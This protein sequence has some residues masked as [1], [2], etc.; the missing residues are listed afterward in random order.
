MN[1][2]AAAARSTTIGRLR[3]RSDPAHAPALRTALELA[4]WPQPEGDAIV[5]VRRIVVRGAAASTLAAAA[6]VRLAAE[7]RAAVAGDAPSAA[8]A[9]AVRFTG[10]AALYAQLSRDLAAGRA[11]RCWYWARWRRLFALPVTSAIPEL[12]REQ[13]LRLAA[14]SAELA[15]SGDLARLWRALPPHEVQRLVQTLAAASGLPP[16]AE[17]AAGR[18]DDP[19]S[20]SPPPVPPPALLSRWQPACRGLP[21]GD[22]RVRLALYLLLLDWRPALA[23]DATACRQLAQRLCGIVDPER[24][25]PHRSLLPEQTHSP[26]LPHPVAVAVTASAAHTE[27]A[28]AAA[29][30]PAS[31]DGQEAS[32]S[33]TTAVAKDVFVTTPDSRLAPVSRER[34]SIAVPETCPAPAPMPEPANRTSRTCLPDPSPGIAASHDAGR[35]GALREPPAST[36]ALSCS[37]HADTGVDDWIDTGSGGLPYLLNVLN[38][39]RVQTLLGGLHGLDARGGGWH[40]WLVLGRALGLAPDD[41]VGRWLE[42]RWQLHVGRDEAWQPQ[43]GDPALVA[44]AAALCGPQ[45]WSPALIAGPGRLRADSTHLD[46]ERPL[47]GVQ[48]AVRRAGLDLDPGWLPWLGRVVAIRYVERWP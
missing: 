1:P 26:A 42:R 32:D 12:W 36:A 29:I 11:A 7:L 39:R 19:A 41:G 14:I 45:L 30:H 38:H 8:D 15:R 44:L 24:P 23:A 37:V 2:A 5:L 43:P 35:S 47:A 4:D 20:A 6:G 10:P 21:A 9:G 22:A 48:L 18:D 17:P 3:L 13:P 33:R 46:F 40:A 27:P 31:T 16:P 34:P 25:A 28:K